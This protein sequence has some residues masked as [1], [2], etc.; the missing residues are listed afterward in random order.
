[1]K[2]WLDKEMKRQRHP[3]T[4]PEYPY[5]GEKAG[6]GKESVPYTLIKAPCDGSFLFFESSMYLERTFYLKEKD[7]ETLPTVHE[8]VGENHYRVV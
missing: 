7:L 3:D 5:K 2:S 8:G 6:F 1:M 4:C